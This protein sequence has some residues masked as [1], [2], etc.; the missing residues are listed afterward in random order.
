VGGAIE[1]YERAVK[2]HRLGKLA[3]E[4][5]NLRVMKKYQL[6]ANA[7]RDIMPSD[8]EYTFTIPKDNMFT[9]SVFGPCVSDPNVKT[10]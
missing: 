5:E 4:A 2:H 7:L 6:W 10:I 8:T 1:H 9:G 3:L